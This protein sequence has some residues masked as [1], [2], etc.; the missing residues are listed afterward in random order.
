MAARLY[1]TQGYS[2]NERMAGNQDVIYPMVALRPWDA[3]ITAA[4]VVKV[5]GRVFRPGSQ[6]RRNVAHGIAIARSWRTTKEQPFRFA[7]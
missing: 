3:D 1:P 2:S 7:E 6:Q 4:D 5:D